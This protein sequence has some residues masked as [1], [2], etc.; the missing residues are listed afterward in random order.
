MIKCHGF[1]YLSLKI[2][3][4]TIQNQSLLNAQRQHLYT[5]TSL[6]Y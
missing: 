1:Y 3:V 6:W 5:H 2:D 4:A